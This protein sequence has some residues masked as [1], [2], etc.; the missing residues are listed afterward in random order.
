MKAFII[1]GLL[2]VFIFSNVLA[3]QRPEAKSSGDKKEKSGV[4]HLDKESF[5]DLVFDY[6]KNKEWNY[7]GKVPAILDFYADWCGPC[8]QVAP[9]LTQMQEE[10]KGNIQVFKV[11]TDVEKELAAIFGIRS[12][13]T[14]V[15]IP[16]DGEPQ[17]ALGA[18]PK[19]ELEKMVT[20]ILKVTK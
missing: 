5:K 11:D 17:A 18:R 9:I 10:Y 19:A 4:I 13:P 14:I 3:N 15:F 6:E 1:S 12:L 8:R 2:F 16:V 20:E 7:N